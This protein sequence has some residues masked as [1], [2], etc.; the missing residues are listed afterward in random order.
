MKKCLY[1]IV[2]QLLGFLFRFNFKAGPYR[3]LN[4]IIFVL[5]LFSQTKSL[6][7]NVLT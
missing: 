3:N 1:T 2:G 4:E 7:W 6:N 5:E